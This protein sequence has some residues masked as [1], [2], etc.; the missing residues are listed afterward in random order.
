M[1]YF[2]KSFIIISGLLLLGCNNSK[3]TKT[4]ETKGLPL[5]SQW[6]LES[7]V[8]ESFKNIQINKNTYITLS[9]DKKTFE[10]MGGCNRMSGKIVVN[11]LNIKFFDIVSTEMACDIMNQEA[12]F[13]SLL[14]KTNRFSIDGGQ[15]ML[16]ENKR[17]L[18]TLE[19]YR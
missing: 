10:G 8:D 6:I 9:E 2:F 14:Q 17:L 16:Y 4:I 3:N 19:S 15:L 5:S 11:N 1:K 13:L 12:V 18:M 7:L